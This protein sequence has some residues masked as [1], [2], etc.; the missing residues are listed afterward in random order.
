M[1]TRSEVANNLHIVRNLRSVL[2][3][4]FGGAEYFE[5]QLASFG[6]NIDCRFGIKTLIIGEEENFKENLKENL[7]SNQ[8]GG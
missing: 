4:Y 8:N 6:G 7:E 5:I 1:C 2:C 3:W